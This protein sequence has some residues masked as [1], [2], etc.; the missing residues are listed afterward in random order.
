MAGGI[1]C[2]LC[3][4]LWGMQSIEC[5]FCAKIFEVKPSKLS[6]G[7]KFCSRLCFAEYKKTPAVRFWRYVIKPELPDDCWLWL[8]TIDKNGYG[9]AG[10][11]VGAHRMSYEIHYGS[12][13]D[14]LLVRHSCHIPRC[15]N[16]KHL[17]IGTT[18][19]NSTDMVQAGRS[20]VGVRNPNVSLSEDDV[21]TI[22]KLYTRK[23]SRGGV[24]LKS[25]AEMF[26]VCPSQIGNIVRGQSWS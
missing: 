20:L 26:G 3:V 8:G 23:Y 12:I 16:P 6:K 21:F 4:V 19:D 2:G 10:V 9:R 18:L 25:L 15:V 14:G 1:N 7:A 13:P 22:R 17:S 5:I 24:T 11:N